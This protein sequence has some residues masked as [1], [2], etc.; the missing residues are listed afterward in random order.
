MGVEWIVFRENILQEGESKFRCY[1]I[2]LIVFYRVEFDID[3]L[4][5]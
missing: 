5:L 4:F 1:F 2:I 3:D